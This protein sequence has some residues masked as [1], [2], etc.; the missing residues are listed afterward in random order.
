MRIAV[1]GT[2]GIG[3]KNGAYSGLASLANLARA[4]KRQAACS[5]NSVNGSGPSSITPWPEVI[6]EVFH[7]LSTLHSASALSKTGLGYF[8]ARM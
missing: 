4:L 6:S 1:V 2:G 8:V 5:S 3:A 7:D